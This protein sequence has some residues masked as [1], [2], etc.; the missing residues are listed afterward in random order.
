MDID[1][2]KGPQG[3][4]CSDVCVNEFRGTF[5]DQREDNKKMMGCDEMEDPMENPNVSEKRIREWC[6]MCNPG[7]YK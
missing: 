2:V 4:T 6:N 7:K 3:S 5:V 1:N